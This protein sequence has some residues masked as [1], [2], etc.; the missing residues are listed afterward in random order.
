CL[1][2]SHPVIQSGVEAYRSIFADEPVVTKWTF[3]TNGVMIAGKHKIPCLGFGPGLEEEAH[4]ANEKL[5]IEHLVASAQFYAGW[6]KS[7][8]EKISEPI[9]LED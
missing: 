1:E 3:S 7:Y 4:A 9:K 5:P 8:V 6:P 2:E